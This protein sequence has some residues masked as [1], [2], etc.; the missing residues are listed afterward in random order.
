MKITKPIAVTDDTLVSCS[1]AENDYPV[2]ESGT[3][4]AAGQKV[5]MT[6]GVHSIFE[7]VAGG[8]VGNDPSTTTGFWIDLGPTNRWAMFDQAVGT[9]TEDALEIVTV[10]ELADADGVDALALL[11]L[12]GETALIEL[13]DAA[14]A[15]LYSEERPLIDYDDAAPGWYSYFFGEQAPVANL[16]LL[17]L[18]FY[19]SARLRVTIS[20]AAGNV[21]IG[22]L[23][24]GRAVEIGITEWAPE[25]GITDYSTKETDE[26]GVKRVV[27]RRYASVMSCD[28]K[29]PHRDLRAM[30]RLLAAIRATPVVW[31]G[32]EDQL[33]DVTIVYGFYRGFNIILKNTRYSFCSLEIEGLT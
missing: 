6:T 19:Y 32:S 17:G 12:S 11:D 10:I 28:L 33:F 2:W 7:S 13:I 24:F 4:Y 15:V 14:D 21:S 20:A 23:A 26:F 16:V 22:T 27:E 29:I 5:I 3:T 30:F 25:I 9:V 31:I 1:V 18:P 8:N